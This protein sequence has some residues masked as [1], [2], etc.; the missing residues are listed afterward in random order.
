MK[1]K[2]QL[3]K[4]LLIVGLGMLTFINTKAQTTYLNQIVLTTGGAYGNPGNHVKFATYEPTGKVFTVRDSPLGDF[5]NDIITDSSFAYAHIGRA[6]GTDVIYKYNLNNYNRVDSIINIAGAKKIVV[7]KNYLIVGRGYGATANY[8]EIFNKKNLQATPVY[9]DVIIPAATSGIVIL[10]DTAYV[11]FTQNDTGKIAIINLK[12]TIPSFV[13]IQ[14]FDTMSSGLGELYTDGKNIFG[15]SE[16][17]NSNTYAF[18]YAKVTVFNPIAKTYNRVAVNKANGGIEING[19]NL[20][21]NFGTGLGTFNTTTSAVVNP[22]FPLS[23]SDG[24]L[25]NVNNRFV[26]QQTDFYSYGRLLI[27]DLSGNRIDSVI[28]DFSGSAVALDYRNLTT[29]INEVAMVNAIRV[30]P[31]PATNF[32]NIDIAVVEEIVQ[33]RIFDITGKELY[34]L[35]PTATSIQLPIGDFTNGIYLINLQTKESNIYKKFIKQ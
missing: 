6:A 22:V 32:I 3:Q 2:T 31:N 9:K 5:S 16:K 1:M 15:L 7:Y 8:V 24:A 28:T 13:R 20:Y 35:K 33:V 34:N 23:Y 18:M 17:Y 25:D 10:R 21:A 30:Y 11:S 29:K 26:F 27:T 4:C 12:N 19:A 14:A